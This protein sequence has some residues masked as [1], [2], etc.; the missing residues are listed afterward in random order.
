MDTNRYNFSLRYNFDGTTMLQVCINVDTF[1]KALDMYYKEIQKKAL[2]IYKSMMIENKFTIYVNKIPIYEFIDSNLSKDLHLNKCDYREYFIGLW[3]YS[4]VDNKSYILKRKYLATSP[5]EAKVLL[6][7]DLT[8][9][10]EESY[11]SQDNLISIRFD[12]GATKK[13]YLSNNMRK[14]E[15]K[16]EEEKKEEELF[17]DEDAL[18]KMSLTDLDIIIDYY[19]DMV[20]EDYKHE[21][22]YKKVTKTVEKI[23]VEKISNVIYKKSEKKENKEYI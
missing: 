12:W 2:D 7:Q 5:Q 11:L 3:D 23:K 18:R 22:S 8:R 6:I 14:K 15:R 9:Q 16:R 13:Q 17:V 10:G 19:K 4:I 21:V 20:Y 1:K